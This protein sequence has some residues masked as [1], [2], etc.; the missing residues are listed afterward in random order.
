MTVLL[1]SVSKTLSNEFDGLVTELIS[2]FLQ[3]A[4]LDRAGSIVVLTKFTNLPITQTTFDTAIATNNLDVIKWLHVERG[5]VLGD[6]NVDSFG[7]AAERGYTDVVTFLAPTD[8]TR[9]A[10]TYALFAAAEYGRYE[11]VDMLS[12][13]C[14]SNEIRIANITAIVANHY[15]LSKMLIT[16]HMIQFP[17]RA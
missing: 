3:P 16:K 12:D 7:I 1:T 14:N 11:I 5:F 2:S 6:D 10:C 13:T 17:Q 15:E 9:G 4:T 8:I